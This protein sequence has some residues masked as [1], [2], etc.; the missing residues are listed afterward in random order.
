MSS[1]SS[2][3]S[4]LSS[5]SSANTSSVNLSS[6]LAAATGASS[7]GIDVTSA[8]EAAIYA[9]QAPERQWQSEQASLQS[10]ITALTSIQTA[11][12]SLSSDLGKLADPL[13]PM[14][15]RTVSSSNASAVTAT[16][17]SGTAAGSHSVTV[18]QLATAASW[19]SPVVASASS[20]LGSSSLTITQANGA[21]TSFSLSASG[22]NTLSSLVSSINAANLGVKASVINDASGVRLAL[23]GSQTGTSAGFTIQDGPASSTTWDSSELGSTSSQLPASSFQVSDGTTSTTVNVTAGA[24]LSDVASQINAS[25]LDLSASVVVDSA[26]AHLAVTSTGGQQVSLSSD[27]TLTMTQASQAKNATLTV[28]GVPVS[29]ASNNVTGALDG[30]TLALTGTT[31]ST[32]PA[33]LTVSANS[34]SISSAVSQFVSDYN[35]TVSLLSAQFT[36]SA[37]SGSEGVLGSDSAVRSLQSALLSSLGYSASGGSSSNSISTLA[38]LGLSMQDD[39]TLT[40]D[41]SRLDQAVASNPAGVQTFFQGASSNGFAN[42]AQEQLAIFSTASSGT[43][44]TDISNLTQQYNNLQSDVNNFESGYIASQKTLLTAM[45]SKAEIALQSLPATMKQIQAELN[46]NSGS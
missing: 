23:V 32:S 15:A 35:S 13:G 24:T 31:S 25:G 37:S 44:A 34:D 41:N 33:V 27:P 20:S 39:G 18:S 42:K 8:V 7:P 3:N 16:A 29:S 43:L 38:D 1:T 22:S 30:V 36:Y 28:D 10:Q 26:G 2:L 19:Y 17:A 9:A 46:N 45:Y 11:A 40:L 12:S 4:L 6:L 21:Q 5:S 14:A